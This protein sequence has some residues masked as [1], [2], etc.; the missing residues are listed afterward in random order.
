MN[1]FASQF[2][3]RN[4]ADR[5]WHDDIIAILTVAAA[6]FAVTPALSFVLWVVTEVQ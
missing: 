6:T 1:D 2:V 5:N 4:C 3:H